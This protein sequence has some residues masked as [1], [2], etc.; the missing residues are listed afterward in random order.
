M[1]CFNYAFSSFEIFIFFI[2]NYIEIVTKY[3]SNNN[4]SIVV[5]VVVVIVLNYEEDIIKPCIDLLQENEM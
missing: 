2:T 5:I 1:I 4:D 3:K